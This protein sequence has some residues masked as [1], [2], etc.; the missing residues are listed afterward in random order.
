MNPAH[1]SAALV[2]GLAL[3]AAFAAAPPAIPVTPAAVQDILYAQPFTLETGYTHHWSKDQPVITSGQLVVFQVDPALVYPR[4]SAEP[5]LYVGSATAERLNVGYTSG[6]V[7]AIVPDVAG[8]D[9]RPV[10]QD[11]S[12]AWFGR[13]GLPAEVDAKVISEEIE[14]SRQAGLRPLTAHQLEEARLAAD[15]TGGNAVVKL[16]R[17]HDLL[18]LAAELIKKYA[19][20][21]VDRANGME[22]ASQA[23]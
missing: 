20:D 11:L 14:R 13:P 15:P 3:S 4:Q 9:G 16:A 21:E 2:A 7:I 23:R 5:V 22:A 18:G 17:K 19:P 1:L 6:R 10:R 8:P 12:K